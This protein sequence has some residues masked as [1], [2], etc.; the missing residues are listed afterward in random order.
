MATGPV[1]ARGVRTRAQL[2]AAARRVFERDGVVDARVTDITREAGVATGSF[3]TYFARKEDAFVAVLDELREEMLHPAG[4][5]DAGG[6]QTGVGRD[7]VATIA[8]A[9]LA[10]LRA[11]ER[12]ARL[13]GL[14][15]QL[16]AFDDEVARARRE[17]GEAFVTR[18]ARAI[19]RLQAQGLADRALDP[20]LAAHAIS[21]MVSRTA[22]QAFVTRTIDATPEQLAEQLTRLWANALRLTPAA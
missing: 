12:N 10:Y 9:N 1:S 17:R 4:L 2:V 13:M 22:A 15:E 6:P 7:A 5:G 20:L 19:A 16:A 18:N 21:A 14:M 8:A 3:Y 11:Y